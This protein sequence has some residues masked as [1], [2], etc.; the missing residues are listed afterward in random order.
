M[1][2]CQS[3]YDQ[4]CFR[5]SRNAGVISDSADDLLPLVVVESLDLVEEPKD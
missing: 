1:L 5:A 2:A 3:K 4:G